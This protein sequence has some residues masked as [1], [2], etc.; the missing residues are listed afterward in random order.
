[1]NIIILLQIF[2]III[3]ITVIVLKDNLKAVIFFSVFSLISAILYF[4]YKAPDL[5]L[6]EAAIGSA[7]TPLIFII[8]ISK[9]REFIVVSG[10]VDD[11]FLNV[12]KKTGIGYVMLKE[13]T[14][15][16]NLK[17]TFVK[18]K[19]DISFNIFRVRNVDL[20]IYKED[21]KYI[22]KANPVSIISNRLNMMSNNYEDI[23][24][25]LI[26]EDEVYD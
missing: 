19:S 14:E 1:M 2:L 6:A 3:A 23:E 16:Y 21:E 11:E 15:H 8:A 13:L 7:I 4:F 25:R 20:F 9:Q 22:F 18:S 24:V 10:K 12:E 26:E 17:L 5:A